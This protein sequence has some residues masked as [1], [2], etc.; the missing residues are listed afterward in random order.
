MVDKGKS[1]PNMD[2]LGVPPVLKV[3]VSHLTTKVEHIGHSHIKVYDFALI[4]PEKIS[5]SMFHC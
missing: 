2:D 4:H 3:R 1:Q 5:D